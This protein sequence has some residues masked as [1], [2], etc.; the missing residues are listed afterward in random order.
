MTIS[1]MCQCPHC[2]ADLR[3]GPIPVGALHLYGDTPTCDRCGQPAHYSRVMGIYDQR[4]DQTVAWRCPDC[5]E[6]WER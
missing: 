3:A 5:R 1:P 4:R 2:H 6:Q